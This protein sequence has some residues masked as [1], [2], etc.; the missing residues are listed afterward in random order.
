[1]DIKPNILII[2]DEEEVVDMLSSGLKRR[3]YNVTAAI[4]I[5]DCKIN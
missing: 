5:T 1:M 2:D 4:T 3:G